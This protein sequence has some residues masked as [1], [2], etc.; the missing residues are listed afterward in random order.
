VNRNI[1]AFLL[2]WV[3]LIA[4]LSFISIDRG[5][6]AEE[7]SEV[8][9]E[10]SEESWTI[11]SYMNGDGDLESFI[12][13]DMNEMERIGSSDNVN[14]IVQIDLGD[15]YRNQDA[16][17]TW[18][19]T[20]R[21]RVEYH[22]EPGLGSTRLD[23]EG[24][25]PELGEVAMDDPDSLEDFIEWGLSNYPADHY[26]IAIEGHADG[27]ADGLMQDLESGGTSGE[28]MVHEMG[29]ALRNAIDGSIGKPVDIIS[30]DVCWM[31]MAEAA[32][33][34]MDH[35]KYMFGS[36]DEIPGAGWPY[37]RCL[38]RI[39]NDTSKPISERLPGVVDEFMDH[40]DPQG[41]NP[42]MSLAAIDLGA[43]KTELVAGIGDLGEEIFY[44]HSGTEEDIESIIPLIDKPF[45]KDDDEWDRYLDLYQ[46]T[47]LLSMDQRLPVRIRE[48][49]GR[50]MATEGDVIIHSDGGSN[51]PSSSRLFGIY[52]PT[53]RNQQGEYS[54][55]VLSNLTAWD[56]LAALR[57]EELELE[58]S[59]INWTHPNPGQGVFQL[60][61]TTPGLVNK[62]EL[63]T[64]LDGSKSVETLVGAGGYYI[65]TLNISGIESILY[66]YSITGK[67]GNRIDIPP[68]GFSEVRFV[69]EDRAPEIWH[70]PPQTISLSTSDSGLT[71]FIRDES[72]I[73]M[74][75]EEGLP[76]LEYREKDNGSWYSI[77]LT[78]TDT[79]DIR[80]WMGYRGLPTGIPSEME[81]EYHIV[82]SDIYGNKARYPETGEAATIMAEGKRFYLDG[83]RSLLQDN[84]LLVNRFRAMGMSVDT[85]LDRILP[86]LTGYK[87][88]ILIEPQKEIS[89]TDASG[90]V[91]FHQGGG[92][93]LL[94]IDP[95]ENDQVVNA[96]WLMDKLGFDV[97][98]EGSVDGFFPS[99]PDSDLGDELPSIAGSCQG[100]IVLG[101]GMQ[102]V[103]YTTP[104]YAAVATG[105]YGLGKSVISIPT[106]L[107]DRVMELQSNRL[108][109]EMLISFLQENTPPILSHEVVPAGVL[110]PGQEFL[111]D[112][113]NSTDRD[114]TI[115][116]FSVTFSD[117]T[118]MEGPEPRF[119]HSFES[120][121]SYSAVISITD[122][123][124]ETSTSTISFKVNRPPGT[125]MGI[126][127]STIHA[128]ETVIFD[129]KDSDPD[130]DEIYILWDFGDGFK[131]SGKTVSHSYGMRGNY[132]YKL[133]VR[134]SNGL[135]RNRTGIIRVENSDPVAE[136]DREKITVNSGPANFTGSSMVTLKVLEG[137]LIRIS[138]ESSHDND[139][140]DGLNFTWEMGDGTILYE[141]A[142]THTY[143]EE[144][145]F[146]LVLT[147][148]DGHGGISNTSLKVSVE[149]REPF[150]MF[151]AEDLG[152]RKVKLDASMSTDDPWDMGG[153]TF[154]WD[155]GD[156]EERESSDPVLEYRY[157]F[158]GRYEVSLEV[159][160]G[161]GASDEYEREVDLE[162]ITIQ[163]ALLI[164]F[165]ILLI[166]GTIG[167]VGILY[168]KRRMREEGKGLRH[169]LGMVEP[170]EV[171]GNHEGGFGPSRPVSL[172]YRRGGGSMGETPDHTAKGSSRD[173]SFDRR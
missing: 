140:E 125:D 25:L 84:S 23:G 21:Y 76:R 68:D 91:A 115:E 72:A 39:L 63:E 137:D 113:S 67:Y 162:G 122:K 96:R 159:R 156:G 136:I 5:F 69:T 128:G 150:A 153:L 26:M 79:G 61:T 123:E 148:N 46:F 52:Y 53:I 135:E 33:E 116:S 43:F 19:E 139:V 106:V 31:G 45:N 108:L 149:N 81:M 133:I 93:I 109:S 130:G 34:I 32:A 18:T 62:V 28:M 47:E 14:I 38:A 17:E 40:Y 71:F 27:P 2:A 126:S 55:L 30:F 107:D 158:G 22:P 138:G 37:D 171:V 57:V 49:A 41:S 155:L 134:D 152:G 9:G 145:M 119:T 121:G 70:E 146:T 44:S 132:T 42:Y 142:A 7:S 64:Y 129:Y 100:S 168:M 114:G 85:G 89:G 97:T 82:V 24:S 120:T 124:G 87:G 94:V 11:L 16:L 157:S 104:P 73:E 54:P 172:N 13:G 147:V 170:D 65:K 50:I 66:R 111:L 59:R 160:D 77:P 98:S 15:D 48:S 163:E 56:E 78:L 127:T 74:E 10:R 143:R 92:E 86:D 144:G 161:D 51:H 118:H 36:F 167:V 112:L 173:L 20:R 35:S 103:Y 80:G 1:R 95:N 29:S 141:T 6:L 12:T 4:S 58:A 60:K 8:P 151:T 90:L 101:Q 169:Y 154:I 83:Y 3:I 131:V 99:S 75:K 166:L 117:N 164:S 110:I 102:P 105:W 165:V 88:Y